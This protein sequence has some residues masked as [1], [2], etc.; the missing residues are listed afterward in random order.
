MALRKIVKVGDELLRKKSKPVH[1]FDENLWELLDDMKET[2]YQNNGMGLAAVQVGVLKRV[3]IIEANNM[4]MELI[5]PEII[6]MRGKDIEKEGCL[7]VGPDYDYVER[8]MQVTV[9]AKDRLGYDFTIT[10][11]KYLAR[12][13]CHEIDHLDGILFIDKVDKEYKKGKK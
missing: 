4:F 6:S 13:L 7:S 9:K 1:D 11:E 8:P 10:G 5:N 3:I 2:M 12:V